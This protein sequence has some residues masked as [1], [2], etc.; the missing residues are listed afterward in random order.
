[1]GNRIS[2]KLDGINEVVTGMHVRVVD[3]QDNT[4]VTV[5]DVSTDSAG[6]VTIGI[7]EMGTIGTQVWTYCDNFDPTAD[8]AIE[9][10]YAAIISTVEEAPA[11]VYDNVIMLGSSSYAR[12]FADPEEKAELQELLGDY[13]L[14]TINIVTEVQ[15]GSSSNYQA[16][17]LMPQAVTNNTGLENVLFFPQSPT[18]NIGAPLDSATNL[19]PTRTNIISI[20]NQAD[21]AGW[22]TVYSNFNTTPN[23]DTFEVDRWNEEFLKPIVAEHA[24]LSLKDGTFVQDYDRI[25]KHDAF[26]FSSSDGIHLKEGSGDRLL[27][28]VTATNLA[29]LMGKDPRRPLAGRRFVVSFVGSDTAERYRHDGITPILRG[30]MPDE[31]GGSTSI[32]ANIIDADTGE[33][34]PDLYVEVS[35]TAGLN[36]G[37]GNNDD[38]ST[39]IGNHKALLGALWKG[40]NSNYEME[41]TIGS[42]SQTLPTIKSLKLAGSRV[43]SS[44]DR[45]G[46]WTHNG[47]VKTLDAA[48]VPYGSVEFSDMVPVD[49]MVK[50]TSVLAAGSTY[51]YLNALECTFA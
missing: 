38:T 34:I 15:S 28:H 45:K 25:S 40:T 13:G 46:E 27:R 39:G 10:Q 22:D 36:T 49:N 9:H 32:G 4:L 48:V 5:N 24:P 21:A 7:G 35:G 6:N 50:L 12:A 33:I 14:P 51:H 29:R 44:T 47:V 18:N 43:A 19:E 1:M 17:T 41:I 2:F 11:K 23:S 30:T 8:V 42:F 16:D 37:R 31:D 20:I 26:T 3:E